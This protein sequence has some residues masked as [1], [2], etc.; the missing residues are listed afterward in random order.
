MVV[1]NEELHSPQQQYLGSMR[2]D[3]KPFPILDEEKLSVLVAGCRAEG[4]WSGI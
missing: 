4:R 2:P 3:D 1:T